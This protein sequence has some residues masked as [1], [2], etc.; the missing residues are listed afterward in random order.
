MTLFLLPR[1]RIELYVNM[2]D[3]DLLNLLPSH[4]HCLDYK[5]STQG[6]DTSHI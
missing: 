5:H 3:L 1:V 4:H 6:L 2:V